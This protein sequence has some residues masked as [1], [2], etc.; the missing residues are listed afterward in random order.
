MEL[1]R[2]RLPHAYAENTPI[3]LTWRLRFTLP[4]SIIR[5]IAEDKEAF[6][7]SISA[8]SVDYQNMQRY[9][10]SK[11]Q[12]D[13]YD[14]MLGKN[15]HFPQL[16]TRPEVA[17][18]IQNS[19]HYLDGDK[20]CLHT[21]CVMSNH[22][23]LL[24]TPLVARSQEKQAL[25]SITQSLK[26]YTARETNKLLAQVGSLWAHE[27]YDHMVRNDKE[28]YRIA[29]YII[30]NPEKAGLVADWKQWQF[31]WIEDELRQYFL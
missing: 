1:Y 5:K 4:T 15:P 27:S 8:L 2:R 26:R 16:L 22:V 7:Q 19:F 31:T 21:F 17:S 3:F 23:H 14:E 24:L 13:I 10:F 18:I 29:W 28:F 25:S 20:Y 30:N 12:F 9:Q 11:K 6:E